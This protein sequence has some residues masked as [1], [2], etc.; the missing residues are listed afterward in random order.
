MAE[1]C[2]QLLR[3]FFRWRRSQPGFC[4]EE[5]TMQESNGEPS[6]VVTTA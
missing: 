2:A 5:T 1:E 6:C 3:D 4:D